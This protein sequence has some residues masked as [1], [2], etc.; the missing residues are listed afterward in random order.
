ML[1]VPVA[2]NDDQAV[3]VRALL[4]G[5]PTAVLV[6]RRPN[7]AIALVLGPL[8]LEPALAALAPADGVI[9][10]RGVEAKAA[11]CDAVAYFGKRLADLVVSRNLRI[12]G[13]LPFVMGQSESDET[14][15][16]SGKLGYVMDRCVRSAGDSVGTAALLV[17]KDAGLRFPCSKFPD[18]KEQERGY[19]DS[20]P[21]L[22][23]AQVCRTGTNWE[24]SR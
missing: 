15:T 18:Q 4:R 10:N 8:D 14:K 17:T 13:L 5:T 24:C 11:A 1:V 21:F 16:P 9:V 7:R 19:A 3:A 23:V 20:R 6:R 22:E 12:H 2:D